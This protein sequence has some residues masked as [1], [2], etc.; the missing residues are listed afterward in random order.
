MQVKNT[1]GPAPIQADHEGPVYGSGICL[2]L[3]YA[4]M[5]AFVLLPE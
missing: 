1:G 5:L 4:E 2:S 3:N